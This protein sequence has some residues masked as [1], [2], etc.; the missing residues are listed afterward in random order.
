VL[1]PT[2]YKFEITPQQTQSQ[3]SPGVFDNSLTNQE[4][5]METTISLRFLGTV[6]AEQGGARIKGF[7][8]RKALALLGYL[9]VQQHPVTR[10]QLVNLLWSDQTEGQ[11]RANLSWV[12][13]HISK[14]LPGCLVTNQHTV[15][16]HHGNA[17]WLDIEAFSELE[18]EDEPAAL[19]DAIM[20]YRGD[21]L[22]GLHLDGCE[23]FELWLT[24]EREHWRQRTVNVLQKLI[25]YYNLRGE[26]DKS[27]Y[28]ANRLLE[29]EPW[30]EATHRHVMRLLARS[31][32]RYAA[33]AQYETCRRTLAED[34]DLEPEAET[35]ALFERIQIADSVRRHTLPPQPTVFIGRE[36]ELDE[37]ARLISS[38]DCR[39]LTIHGPG[40]IGK[41][42]LALQAAEAQTETFLEGICFVP[43]VDVSSP[44]YLA[45]AIADALQLSLSGMQSDQVQLLNYLRC[46]EMLLILDN[47]EHLLED[48]QL[49]EEI[50]QEAPEMKLL[51]TSRERL[52]LPSERCFE[53]DGL[54][55]PKDETTYGELENY[56]AVQLLVQTAS[57]VQRQFS[58]T[59]QDRLAAVHICQLV[60]GMPLG[61]ELAAAWTKSH[62]CQEVAEAIERDVGFLTSSFHDTPERHRSIRISFEHSWNL[63]SPIEQ[64]AFMQLSVFHG[65]L[66]PEA[67]NAVA[68]ATLELLTSLT[69][70]SLIRLL[71]SGRYEIHELLRQYAA[72]K[73]APV[74]KEQARAHEQHC[75][76]YISFLQDHEVDLTGPEAA[77]ILP[78]VRTELA[79]VSAAWKWAVAQGRLT[80]IARG[81]PGLSRFCLLSGHYQ[82]G[83]ALL[84][85]AAGQ[86]RDLAGEA[87]GIEYSTQMI[88]GRV[89]AEAALFLNRLGRYEQAITVAEEAASQAQLERA[90]DVESLAH[91][92]RGEALWRQGAFDA[93]EEQF[94][95]ALTL[96]QTSSQCQV[97]AESLRSLGNVY[98]GRGAF[99]NAKSYYRH[100]Q[101]VC[102]KIGDRL[103]EGKSLNN[104]G[105][106]C[107]YLGECTEARAY[108]EQVL[109][110]S[111]QIGDSSLRGAALH[112]LARVCHVQ[113][114]YLQSGAYLEEAMR[115][116]H[117]IGDRQNEAMSIFH[118]GYFAIDEGLYIK[119]QVLCRQAL[120]IFREIGTRY[121]EDL[122]LV[123]LGQ[124]ACQQGSYVEAIKHLRQAL[125]VS[126]QIGNQMA[127]SWALNQLGD[128][129]T[130][131]GNYVQSR[132]HLEQALSIAS[133][134]GD[135]GDE[136]D[137]LASLMLL[138]NCLKDGKAA[139]EAGQRA[140]LLAKKMGNRP[141]QAY[142]LT[143][144][145]QA[146]E[147]LGQLEEAMKSYQQAFALRQELG[148]SNLT[149]EPLAGLA[150]VA[151]AQGLLPQARV[152]VEDILPHLKSGILAGTDDPFMIYLTC[153]HVLHKSHDPRGQEILFVA[154]DLLQKQAARMDDKELR[155]TFLENVAAHREI[156]EL[157]GYNED[158][159]RRVG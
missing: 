158:V 89:L 31:G 34:L 76:Y 65:G 118:F 24:G 72:E 59:K 106:T 138:A 12:L 92:Q 104:L 150:R 87:T 47:F 126:R 88:L 100:A 155:R 80:E 99:T 95:E 154:H 78:K 20:L 115:I 9:A 82:E 30:E 130:A 141:G 29:L 27:L 147:H 11:G 137:I 142:V 60:Q 114:D 105:A 71:P 23:Q 149:T 85:L 94:S 139:Q 134:I 7:R 39:M 69:D 46:K 75:I 84:E 81:L 40:G 97:E 41:T 25:T 55:Y 91:L 144:Q 32:Q 117:H 73:L 128:V 83:S 122:A 15:Q 120:S 145:G 38:S 110:I 42:R 79:N 135:K 1:Q 121:G 112:N 101:D 13:N 19:V 21:F 62:T 64:D 140:L 2:L 143:L 113:G 90:A 37:V 132:I 116:W 74:L 56:S 93:A 123:A 68:G 5:T 119:A 8:S 146:F 156:I 151:L 3:G 125:S 111:R 109:D 58:L 26:H 43:L 10:E 107:L 6:Q 50:L 48:V 159:L 36:E 35:T 44:A 77:S 4:T 14:Y 67:A 18:V 28:F 66:T 22:E 51:I 61:I 45:S 131:T 127:E 148:L 153:Y 33:L 63:L 124:L 57:R 157:V 49:L 17:Y 98:H 16:L 86:L 136:C 53:L 129:Y 54:R 133:E 108:Y 152:W 52:N 96:A 102:H 70:K 103:G